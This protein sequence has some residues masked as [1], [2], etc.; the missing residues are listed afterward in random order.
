MAFK[1]LVDCEFAEAVKQ[2][3]AGYR[4]DLNQNCPTYEAHQQ[5]VE[6]AER[7]DEVVT[8][9]CYKFLR[10]AGVSVGTVLN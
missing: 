2:I 1:R 3:Y 10:Q 7:Y 4:P 5:L 6:D 8:M 9:L